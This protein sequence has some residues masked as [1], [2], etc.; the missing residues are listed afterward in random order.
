MRSPKTIE[1]C[2]SSTIFVRISW[3]TT[4]RGNIKCT[5]VYRSILF[6]EQESPDEAICLS[7]DRTIV[8]WSFFFGEG[9][10]LR[11]VGVERKDSLLGRK[12]SRGSRSDPHA[13]PRRCVG[14][15]Q[16]RFQCKRLVFP[17]VTRLALKGFYG[18][19]AHY[20]NQLKI[21][22]D[23]VSGQI[24]PQHLLDHW[25]TQV[26]KYN[27]NT[28]STS[29]LKRVLNDKELKEEFAEI[30]SQ[31]GCNKSVVGHF[32]SS[33]DILSLSCS[34]RQRLCRSSVEHRSCLDRIECLE[35]SIQRLAYSRDENKQIRH[36]R[37]S[38]CRRLSTS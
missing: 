27:G 28:Q 17:Q 34:V 13:T 11:R 15:A 31:K 16:S 12:K 35:D 30:F 32:S 3:I 38:V 2:C 18:R 20:D 26:H 9:F 10:S 36:C 24:L 23:P 22:Q 1:R 19:E 25:W 5:T 33:L 4:R 6:V 7:G 37:R 21:I 8:W 29:H 14:L